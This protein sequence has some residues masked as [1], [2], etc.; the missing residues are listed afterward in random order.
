MRH[1]TVMRAFQR[2]KIFTRLSGIKKVA[3][4]TCHSRRN[5]DVVH[6]SFDASEKFPRVLLVRCGGVREH[7]FRV[8]WPQNL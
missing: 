5:N 6:N 4:D 8:Y 1:F 7:D 2:D 3:I